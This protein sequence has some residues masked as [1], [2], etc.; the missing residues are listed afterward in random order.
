MPKIFVISDT[1]F[2]RV[3]NDGPDVDTVDSNESIIFNWNTIVTPDDTVYVLGGVGILD[4]YNIVIQLKGNIHFL[5]NVFN[6]DE[7][8]YIE[9]LK[10][11]IDKS[12]DI[13][14][15]ER[16]IFEDDQLVVLSDKDVILTYY[17]LSVWPGKGVDVFCF[18]GYTDDMNL[19]EQNITS[20]FSKWGKHID[21]DEIKSNI[22][23]FKT[24]V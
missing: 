14:L 15:Q 9:N 16:L 6:P 21:I 11:S 10:E 12:G 5:N 13:G 19:E 2:N 17:P 18:H 20:T 23:N 1:W 3:L 4:L 8:M 22:Q 24:L 7:K